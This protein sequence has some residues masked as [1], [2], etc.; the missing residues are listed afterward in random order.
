MPG[1]DT[2]ELVKLAMTPA[3]VESDG[4]VT[5]KRSPMFEVML[6]PSTYSH[7]YAIRYDQTKTF[8][9]VGTA[10]K[11]SAVGPEQVSFDIMLDG[12]GVV[13]P[14]Q[15][16][17]DVRTRIQQLYTVV[18]KYDGTN[19][20]PNHVRILWGSLIFFGRL[21]SMSLDYTLFEPSGQPLR[22]KVKLAF[23]GFMTKEE[24]VLKANSSSPDLSHRVEVKA[25]DTL[26]LLCYRIYSDASYYLEVAE[27][28]NLTNF[29]DLQPG[30]W[31]D[32]PPL[33]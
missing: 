32:F 3:E 1:G 23:V 11:F 4:S 26:P 17:P 8:G 30:V 10:S 14:G 5:V 28:N 18:Y 16:S 25:G 29:R 24:Q 21:E 12:T 33:R 22:A 27:I 15:G 20:Q 19:H 2:G 9:Q 7:Q 13:S 31:L 6:N